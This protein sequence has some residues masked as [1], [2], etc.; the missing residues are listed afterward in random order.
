MRV[1]VFGGTFDPPHAGHLAFAQ[2]ALGQLSLDEL[3]WMP[4]NR[5]PAKAG[6]KQTP[7][8]HRL[9]MVS[10]VVAQHERMAASDLEISRGGPSYAVDTLTELAHARPAEYWFLVGADAVRELPSWKQPRRLLQLCRLAVAMRPPLSAGD[11]LARIPSEFHA[12]IDL[13][14]MAPNTA[15]STDVRRAIATQTPT[16]DLDPAVARYIAEHGLYRE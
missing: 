5:N 2:A 7:A 8:R 16:H 10:L 6:R 13:V 12:R 15:S 4:A 9:A 11:V 14:S 1:G 3:L